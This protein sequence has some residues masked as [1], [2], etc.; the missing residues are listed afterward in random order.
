M[1]KTNFGPYEIT[2]RL[3]VGKAEF[4]LGE[5]GVEFVTFRHRKDCHSYFLPH[6]F[7]DRNSA[8]DDLIRRTV[9]Y[10]GTVHQKR[11]DGKE[12]MKSLTTVTVG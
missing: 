10:L 3:D 11:K 1:E 5:N 12:S 2:E 7:H 4:V 8:V 6:R 9:D